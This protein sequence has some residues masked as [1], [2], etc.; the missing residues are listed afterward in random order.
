M[1]AASRAPP[2]TISCQ[3]A[4]TALGALTLIGDFTTCNDFSRSRGRRRLEKWTL[5][6]RARLRK[7]L[8]RAQLEDED[9]RVLRGLP[10]VRN[11]AALCREPTAEAGGDRHE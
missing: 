2:N 8:C 9:T 11:H 4:W 7:G 10:A 1:P 3:I 5:L 6:A